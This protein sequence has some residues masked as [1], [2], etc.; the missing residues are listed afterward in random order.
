MNDPRPDY[1]YSDTAYRLA[2]FLV[3]HDGGIVRTL[4]YIR[5]LPERDVIREPRP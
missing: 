4:A 5:S 3:D 2:L 1:F